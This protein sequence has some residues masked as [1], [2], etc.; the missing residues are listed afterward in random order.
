M[1]YALCVCAENH[2]DRAL[3]WA[4]SFRETNSD[5]QLVIGI[6]DSVLNL[7]ALPFAGEL[8]TLQD[9]NLGGRLMGLMRR[10]PLY[11]F[12]C[13]LKAHF[14]RELFRRHPEAEL[15][16]YFDADISLYGSLA[17]VEEEMRDASIGITPHIFDPAQVTTLERGLFA[18][19]FNAGFM[20]FRRHPET[21]AY[22][23]FMCG[24]PTEGSIIDPIRGLFFDQKWLNWVPILFPSSRILRSH[25]LNFAYWN[26]GER[27]LS[28]EEN[29]YKVGDDEKLVFVHFSGYSPGATDRATQH[30]GNA[31]V[32]FPSQLVQDLYSEYA[33]CVAEKRAA[34]PDSIHSTYN[35]ERR[36]I[37]KSYLGE[38]P[39]LKKIST[40]WRSVLRMIAAHIAQRVG[41]REQE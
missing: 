26:F 11:E 1:N 40:I 2:L 10:M 29:A 15:V 27:K 35:E 7:E 21:R 30:P 24:A 22:L 12:N 5:Y 39:L 19:I 13:A 16:L 18:G 14:L 34:I 41:W 6:G 32:H 17:D 3:V 31:A 20:A 28:K 9:L 38:M 25:G 4:D 33:R 37:R 8:L 23:D 36:A